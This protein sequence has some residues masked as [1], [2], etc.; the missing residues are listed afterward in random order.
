MKT[1]LLNPG[2]VSL[3]DGVRDALSG[4]DICHR[5]PE[6]GALQD[7]LRTRLLEVYDLDPAD[8]AA[9]LLTGSG[10]AAVEAMLATLA[11]DTG[12]LL[13]MENGVYGERM[14]AIAEAYGLPHQRLPQ[15]WGAP[16]DTAAL[17]AMLAGGDTSAAAVVH[18]ETTTGRLNDLD[19]IAA[20]TRPAGAGLLLDAVSSFGAEDIRFDDWGVDAV[21]AT[22]NKCLH[23][24]P[25][26]SFVIARRAALARAAE[27][28]RARSVYLD[29]NRYFEAQERGGT[30]FTQSVQTF[31]AL[32]AA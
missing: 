21:A 6:F 22:A 4:P 7:E 9:V 27:R 19:A 26:T 28:N 11:P 32:R 24:V 25:G 2:P 16:V 15:D 10:T 30:P 23:G 8:W 3:S 1:I 12:T 29:L 13:S 18:H 17:A 31:Y 20:H 14:T 5:E